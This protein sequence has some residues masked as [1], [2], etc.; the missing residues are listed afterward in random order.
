MVPHEIFHLAAPSAPARLRFELF[1][2]KAR[3]STCHVGPHFIEE[4]SHNRWIAWR[5]GKLRRP[6]GRVRESSK[7]RRFA[8]STLSQR[9]QPS[10]E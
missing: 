3:C 8:K 2:R 4:N 6:R 5:D 1:R 9:T 10:R 7:R